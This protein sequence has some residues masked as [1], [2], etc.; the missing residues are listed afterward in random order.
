MKI[1]CT[2]ACLTLFSSGLAQQPAPSGDCSLT[3]HVTGVRNAKGGV[4]GLL[5]RS[6]EGWP[7]NRDKAAARGTFPIVDGKSTLKFDH[8]AAGQYAVVVL[9]DENENKKLDR[10]FLTIPKEGFGFANNPKVGLSAPKFQTATINIGGPS[11]EIEIRM[12]YK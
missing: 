2:I 1:F 10:N 4:G 3:I 7:E 11:T 8:L 9:H 5:F 12:T 6:T